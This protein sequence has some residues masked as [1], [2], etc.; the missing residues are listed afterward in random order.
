MPALKVRNLLASR[1]KFGPLSSLLTLEILDARP[2]LRSLTPQPGPLVTP[3]RM[4]NPPF[5]LTEFRPQFAEPAGRRTM[6]QIVDVRSN[7]CKLGV[8]FLQVWRYL[9]PQFIETCLRSGKSRTESCL[10]A[11]SALLGQGGVHG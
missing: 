3:R 5:Q 7:G 9:F 11:A 10:G 8:D 2:K 1:C 6:L 4:A